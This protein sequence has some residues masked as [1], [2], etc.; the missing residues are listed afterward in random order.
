MNNIKTYYRHFLINYDNYEEDDKELNMFILNNNIIDVTETKLDDKILYTVKYIIIPEVIQ[1]LTK[2]KDVAKSEKE[3]RTVNYYSGNDYLA[4]L[5]NPMDAA[6]YRYCRDI[7]NLIAIIIEAQSAEI[8]TN[9][10][11][12]MA[13]KLGEPTLNTLRHIH[14]IPN[15]FFDLL[16]QM[17]TE[18]YNENKNFI[19]SQYL[20]NNTIS[21]KLSKTQ[22][23]VDE[24]RIKYG[25]LKGCYRGKSLPL[26]L[27]RL[28]YSNDTDLKYY[29]SIVGNTDNKNEAFA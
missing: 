9:Y 14:I 15:Y 3:N 7:R 11:I 19:F 20:Q 25:H 1:Q 21:S 27:K 17:Y 23:V 18:I 5:S 10:M 6:Y 2:N 13:V 29:N 4:M 26:E 28:T 12:Y 16:G 22:K 8:M 24:Y